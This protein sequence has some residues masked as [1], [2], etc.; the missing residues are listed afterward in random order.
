MFRIKKIKEL[1]VLDTLKEEYFSVASSPLDGMWHFGF[2]PLAEHFGFYHEEDLVGFFCVDKDGYV[3]QYFVLPSLVVNAGSL[4]KLLLQELT[5]EI[6]NI[7]GAVVSTAEPRY[8]SECLEYLTKPELVAKTYIAYNSFPTNIEMQPAEQGD[9]KEFVELAVASTD[10]PST[11]VTEY[12]NGLMAREELWGYWR[13]TTLVAIG[14]CRLFDKY[15]SEHAELGVIVSLFE[16][17][18]GVATNVLKYLACHAREIG[19]TA[20]CSTECDN[21]AAQKAITNAGFY[22][23]NRIVR[24]KTHNR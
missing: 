21:I 13:D 3:L 22:A 14:E 6:G 5:P 11:W 17:S 24:F 23:N 12:Y 20:I 10:L 1:S 2:V 15:Q 8:L 4:F 7:N 19:L 18:N 9:L 16:R